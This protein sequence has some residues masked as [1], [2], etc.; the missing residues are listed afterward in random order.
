MFGTKK[1]EKLIKEYLNAKKDSVTFNPSMHE[2]ILSDSLKAYEK[3]I[4]ASAGTPKTNVL[5][6]KLA[7]AAI[8]IITAGLAFIHINKNSGDN[9]DMLRI[10]LQQINDAHTLSYDVTTTNNDAIAA[11]TKW[12][13]KKAEFVKINSDDG[14]FAI[15]FDNKK[16]EGYGI[17][18][19]EKKYIELQSSNTLNITFENSFLITRKLKA[20]SVQKNTLIGKKK[21]DGKDVEG[22]SLADNDCVVNIWIES[23]TA[24]PALMEIEFIKEPSMRI[25][26]ND[27]N[28]NTKMYAVSLKDYEKLPIQINAES[29]L[30]NEKHI[31]EFFG[32][33]IRYRNNGGII[34]SQNNGT[35]FAKIAWELSN[36]NLPVGITKYLANFEIV[37]P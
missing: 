28:I 26:V 25:L 4:I 13:F 36:Q 15:I 16:N 14:S 3:S 12:M 10:A 33:L 5:F 22:F 8:I 11:K 32:S 2:K 9:K 24:K 7:V 27:F 6:I 29:V 21:I 1:I 18:S 19:Q 31:N 35:E 30:E 23:S 17:L 34:P 37:C 20:F